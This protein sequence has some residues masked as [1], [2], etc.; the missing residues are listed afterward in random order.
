MSK[1]QLLVFVILFVVFSCFAFDGISASFTCGYGYVNGLR[2]FRKPSQ[3]YVHLASS[4]IE[5]GIIVDIPIKNKL[6]WQG[7]F[8][9]LFAINGNESSNRNIFPKLESIQSDVKYTDYKAGF[10]LA[11]DFDVLSITGGLN[12]T[13][14]SN[15]SFIG[16]YQHRGRKVT[17]FGV[18]ARLCKEY[19]MSE[20]IYAFGDAFGCLNFS[21][22]IR[23]FDP[24]KQD[25]INHFDRQ[26]FVFLYSVFARIGIKVVI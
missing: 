20:K 3:D 16:D 6:S 2:E 13:G 5:T 11:F 17:S 12:F 26:A 21:G 18:Y 25:W 19:Q 22:W 15:H 8:S 23:T 14:I 9:Y 24:E 7:F 4:G 10:G 1:K